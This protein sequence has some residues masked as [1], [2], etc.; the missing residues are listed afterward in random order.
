MKEERTKEEEGKEGLTHQTNGRREEVSITK[1][2]RRKDCDKI[3]EN[4]NAEKR[5][6]IKKSNK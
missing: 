4:K 3:G 2:Q 6:K 1:E 5:I